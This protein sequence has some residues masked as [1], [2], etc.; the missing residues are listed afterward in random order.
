M[1]LTLLIPVISEGRNEEV[2][3]DHRQ[4]LVPRVVSDFTVDG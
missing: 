3:G 1:T 4:Q 2:P